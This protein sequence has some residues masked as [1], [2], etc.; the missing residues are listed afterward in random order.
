[1]L[2]YN[3]YNTTNEN[4]NENENIF[5]LFQNYHASMRPQIHHLKLDGTLCIYSLQVY[6]IVYSRNNIVIIYCSR[7][8]YLYIIYKSRTRINR[9]R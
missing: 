2:I 5:F 1:M 4:L 6:Y 3:V 9:K 8:L 7:Y